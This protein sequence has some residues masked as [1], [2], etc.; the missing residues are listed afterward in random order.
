MPVSRL[1]APSQR[2]LFA[3]QVRAALSPH[4]PFTEHVL[5]AMLFGRLP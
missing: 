3:E 1:P 2:P 5:V 4:E